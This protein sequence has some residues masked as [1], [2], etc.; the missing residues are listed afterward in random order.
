M[1]CEYD[2]KIEELRRKEADLFN[3]SES[4]R[5]K[6]EDLE[7]IVEPFR[8]QLDSYKMEKS[9]LL[10][11]SAAAESE[12]KKLSEEYARLIGHNNHKQKIQH[13][14][15]LK[16]ENNELR[17]KTLKLQSEL[18]K[19]KRIIRRLEEKEHKSLKWGKS[20][21]VSKSSTVDKDDKENALPMEEVLD[22]QDSS[23]PLKSSSSQANR[24]RRI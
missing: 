4:W 13:L 20:F 18:D 12:L 10:S 14:V 8:D 9:F 19:Q 24:F 23:T 16:T 5:T 1:I 3:E 11:K 17:E 7:K 15:K 22:P 21:V 2:E 6:Y